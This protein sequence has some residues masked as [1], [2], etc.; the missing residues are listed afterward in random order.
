MYRAKRLAGIALGAALLASLTLG[1][2][3]LAQDT[4]S[5][6][7]QLTPSRDSG[8]SGTAVLTDVQGGV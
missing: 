2:T 6:Q 1:G 3:A 7:L 5:V 4:E 8:V